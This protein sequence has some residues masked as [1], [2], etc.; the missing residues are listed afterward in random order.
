MLFDKMVV[1]HSKLNYTLY[2]I[3]GIKYETK[4]EQYMELSQLPV[5]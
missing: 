4:C 5:I 1:L 2:L 3:T